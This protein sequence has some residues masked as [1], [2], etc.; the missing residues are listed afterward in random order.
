MRG[1]AAYPEMHEEMAAM[2]NEI[3]EKD[4]AP[5]LMHHGQE[6]W[7]GRGMMPGIEGPRDF[8]LAGVPDLLVHAIR[9]RSFRAL[10][11]LEIG[12]DGPRV[13][14]SVDVHASDMRG[15]EAR[16]RAD[17]SRR[18]TGHAAR[19]RPPRP[20][21]AGRLDSLLRQRD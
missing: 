4:G 15:I 6:V 12:E 3:L 21:Y 17:E 14:C 5:M 13:L 2:G 10:R 19:G 1:G 20:R 18:I 11:L 7:S 9:S 16:E 8:T